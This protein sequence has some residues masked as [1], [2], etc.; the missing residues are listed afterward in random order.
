MSRRFKTLT[1]LLLLIAGKA[2]LAAPQWV[3]HTSIA[4][5]DLPPVGWSRFDDLFMDAA[6]HYQIPYPFAE[7]VRFLEAKVDNGKRSGVRQVFIPIGRSL[8][9]DAPAPDFFHFPR[10]LVALQGEPA[11]GTR[12]LEYRLF[13]A[14]QPSTATLEVISYNDSAGRFEFQVVDAYDARQRPQVRQANRLMCL[15]CHQNAAPIFAMRP[16][17]ETNFNVEVAARLHAALPARFKSFVGSLSADAGAIDLLAERANY[18]AAAQLIWQ[19]GCSDASC[20]AAALRALL[21]YRLSGKTNFARS[22]SGYRRDYVANLRRNWRRIWPDGL[23]LAN[24]R[25]VDRNPFARVP[26]T[27]TEDALS[28]RPPHATWRDVDAIVADGII[29]RLAGFMTQADIRRLD[30]HLIAASK[31]STQNNERLEA[32]CRLVNH[33]ESTRL[34]ECADGAGQA[35]LRA[36]IE[37]E[38]SLGKVQSMRLLSLRLADEPGLL[39]PTIV[40]LTRLANGLQADLVNADDAISMRLPGGDRLSSLKLHWQDDSLQRENHLEIEIAREFQVIEQAL[41]SMLLNHRKG[42]GASLST[43]P[44]QRE[45]IMAELGQVLGLVADNNDPPQAKRQ[46]HAQIP[47]RTL[48]LL[49]GEQAGDLALLQPYCGHCHGADTLAPPGFLAGSDTTRHLEQCAAR[50]LARLLA[51]HDPS[52]QAIAPMP[53]PASI[54]ANWSQSEDYF[55]LTAAIGEQLAATRGAAAVIGA[56]AGSYDLLPPCKTID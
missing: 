40:N 54:D 9:R 43:R 10:A 6:G 5:P 8:Q 44:F 31:R 19:Q 53:P 42:N 56:T 49:K 35:S 37:L 46:R 34:L 38:Y 20:R 18:L 41:A 2:A 24:S 17:S 45:V 47:P 39:E 21:Q 29:I 1:V 3:V 4:S 51:W 26:L 22:D 33:T 36:T 30:R 50:I 55:K 48:P 13:I 12:V 27:R 25:I 14:H 11:A 7:L 28:L 23:A 15:S 52:E 32:R 16:W